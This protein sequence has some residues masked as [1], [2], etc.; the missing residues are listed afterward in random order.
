MSVRHDLPRRLALLVAE[1]VLPEPTRPVLEAAALARG[2]VEGAVPHAELRAHYEAARRV[3]HRAAE[4]ELEVAAHLL[5]P[6]PFVALDLVV[7]DAVA[8][9]PANAALYERLYWAAAEEPEAA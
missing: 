6:D 7:G 3:A 9:D 8:L 4:P 1:L 2:A 5:H